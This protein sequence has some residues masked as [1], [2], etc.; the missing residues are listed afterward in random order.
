MR[1]AAME[2]ARTERVWREHNLI[3]HSGRAT[4]CR[5]DEQPGRFRK[6]Q[7]KAGCP[8][9]WCRL[10][11]SEK[12]DGIPTLQDRRSLLSFREWSA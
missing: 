2:R 6:G 5:C 10:C 7:K 3:V 9:P 12:L 8:D 1:R 11:K 4:G